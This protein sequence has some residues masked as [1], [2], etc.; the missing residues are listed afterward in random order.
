MGTLLEKAQ[1]AKVKRSGPIEITQEHIDLALAWARGEIT[2]TQVVKALMKK[3]ANAN[4]R[5][6][7]I[8]ITLARALR[9]YINKKK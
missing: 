1:K 7:A 6:M 8:Y 9:E 5:G 4:Y 3:G 2:H